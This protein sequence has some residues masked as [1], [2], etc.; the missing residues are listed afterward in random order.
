MKTKAERKLFITT[1]RVA[2]SPIPD[3]MDRAMTSFCSGYI[4]AIEEV[5]KLIQSKEEDNG[6]KE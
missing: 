2:T 4:H 1:Y 5:Q 3:P 6:A